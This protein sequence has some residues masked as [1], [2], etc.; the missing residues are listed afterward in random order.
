M[1]SLFSLFLDWL[2]RNVVNFAKWSLSMAGG[3][4]VMIKPTFPFILICIA[5]VICDCISAFRLVRRM[6]KAGKK[7]TDKVRSDKMLKALRTSV[8]GMAAVVLAFVIEK[9]ILVMHS[10]LYLANYT[11]LAFCF[12]QFWSITENES[13]CNGSKWA[14]IAQKFMVDKT[15]RHLDV[16]LSILKDKEGTNEQ[17]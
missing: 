17:N 1:K 14:A 2:F 8:L 7:V 6:K 15:E 3:F 10:D 16:D 13:S 4:L 12:I 11:A 5:F 9:F